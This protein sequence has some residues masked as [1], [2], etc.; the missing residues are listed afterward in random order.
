[1]SKANWD[2]YKFL[3]IIRLKGIIK[4]GNFP[5]MLFVGSEGIGKTTISKLFAREFLGKYHDANLK[6]VHANV[7]LTDEE[8]A[9]ARSE[10]YVSTSKTDWNPFHVFQ[11]TIVRT[12]RKAEKSSASCVTRRVSATL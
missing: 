6:I 9:Q 11:N 8:R 10:A 1:M 7:P 2:I 4:Q 12:I 3:F 5:H